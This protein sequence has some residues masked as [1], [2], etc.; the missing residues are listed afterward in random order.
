MIVLKLNNNFLQFYRK[1]T[2]RL[3]FLLDGDK[4]HSTELWIS[5]SKKKLRLFPRNSEEYED[6]K[7][8][9]RSID[10]I[11]NNKVRKRYKVH[12]RFYISL[13][14]SYENFYSIIE[15]GRNTRLN[16]TGGG[17]YP[18]RIKYDFPIKFC[19]DES[20]KNQML[21]LLKYYGGV[22]NEQ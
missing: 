3:L 11:S 17:A 1:D 5:L 21:G 16:D 4:E 18:F 15:G 22:I 9:E 7:L 2:K 10:L 13:K 19:K 6:D 8:F 20:L 14:N 12:K